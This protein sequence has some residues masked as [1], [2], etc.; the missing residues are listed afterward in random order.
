MDGQDGDS[1][2]KTKPHGNPYPRRGAVKKQ[3]IKDWVGGGGGGDDGNGGGS[4]DD[5]SGDD[6]NG[7]GSAAAGYYGAD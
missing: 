3:I 6:G 7:G 2:K 1:K 4:G 5:G